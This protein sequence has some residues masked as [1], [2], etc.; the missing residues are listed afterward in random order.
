MIKNK[1]NLLGGGVDYLFPDPHI[2]STPQGHNDSIPALYRDGIFPPFMGQ[3]S[4][5]A[6]KVFAE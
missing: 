5:T 4:H 1:N 2:V 3:K 6:D